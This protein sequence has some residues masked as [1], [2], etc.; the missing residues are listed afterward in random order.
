MDTPP[1]YSGTLQQACSAAASCAA[2]PAQFAVRGEAGRHYRVE[3]PA[4]APAHPIASDGPSLT[5]A[6]LMHAFENSDAPGGRGLLGPGGGGS[7]RIGGTLD[8][9]AATPAGT[10]RAT[11]D[12]VVSYD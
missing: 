10:Y 12:I 7:F 4:E 2:Q 8:I 6:K 3:Y 11:L 5:V 9:P 1:T